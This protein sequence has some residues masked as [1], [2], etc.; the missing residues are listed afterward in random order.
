MVI[1]LPFEIIA[2]L[3]KSIHSLIPEFRKKKKSDLVAF[4]SAGDPGLA[5]RAHHFRRFGGAGGAL[6]GGRLAS[7]PE[8]YGVVFA[9]TGRLVV[10]VADEAERRFAFDERVARFGVILEDWLTVDVVAPELAFDIH[11][12]P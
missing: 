1:H 4:K 6:D 8:S 12:V 7:A 3:N 10:V 2:H 9:E 5:F 11:H